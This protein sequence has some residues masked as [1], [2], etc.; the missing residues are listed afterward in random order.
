MKISL[1]DT[2]QKIL[3]RIL[4]ILG[5]AFVVSFA[6]SYICAASFMFFPTKILVF[7]NI[8]LGSLNLSMYLAIPMFTI[9]TILYYQR[10]Q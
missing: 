4:A 1:Y 3:S 10:K 6:I 2:T 8:S 7:K 9:F 5:A